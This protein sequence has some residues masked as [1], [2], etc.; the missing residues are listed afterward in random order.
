MQIPK[1][2]TGLGVTTA[3][4][5]LISAGLCSSA[6]LGEELLKDGGF[7]SSTANGTFP[8]SGYWVKEGIGW[9]DAV[10]TTTAGRV[11]HGLWLYTGV[12]SN[13]WWAAPYQQVPATGGT[14]YVGS[15]WIRTPAGQA[16]ADGTRVSVHV[17]F[18]NAKTNVITCYD[19][20]WFEARSL[21]WRQYSVVTDAA[22][23]DTAWARLSCVIY[24]PRGVEGQSIVNFDLCSLSRTS[25]VSAQLSPRAVGF[26][27]SAT[28]RTVSLRNTGTEPFSW[29]IQAQLDGLS[30]NPS[31]G[32]LD[33]ASTVALNLYLNRALLT[34]EGTVS[35]SFR[36]EGAG[37]NQI[38]DVFVEST[39]D[40]VPRQPS[41]VRCYGRQLRVQDRLPDG[42]LGPPYHYAIRGVAWSPA[43]I[44]TYNDGVV[45]RE[46]FQTWYVADTQL[47]RAMNAN[48]VYTFM[49]FGTDAAGLN[50]LDYLYRNGLKA[51]VTVDNNGTADTNKIK[52][53]IPAYRDHP[54]V[55]A[56]AIG[57]EW[58]INLYHRV[59]P[60]TE[61]PDAQ[62]Q[63]FAEFTDQLAQLVKSLDT[64]HP[65]VSI[66]GDIDPGDGPVAMTNI[67]N[68]FAPTV[69]IWGLNAY[70]GPSFEVS[71]LGNLFEDWSRITSEVPK[72]FFL[73]EFGTDVF[74]TRNTVIQ[75]TGPDQVDVVSADG[76]IDERLQANWVRGLWR[77][78]ANHLSAQAIDDPCVGGCI[79]EWNDEWWKARARAGA[80]PGRQETL[81]FWTGWNIDALADSFANE[82]FFAITTIDRVPRQLY[83]YLQED[84]AAVTLSDDIDEDGLPDPW[85]YAV[86]DASETDGLGHISAV[87]PGDDFDGDGASNAL[88]YEADTDPLEP[89]SFL[90]I[91]GLVSTDG[92]LKVEWQGG[93]QAR[94]I[95]EAAEALGQVW[96][97]VWTN[98]P[99]TPVTGLYQEADPGAGGTRYFR[100]RVQR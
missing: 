49:D 74:A 33:A 86:V 55:L 51:I 71:A 82:E 22:P 15:A 5:T 2:R 4:L 6:A 78:I 1:W 10:C 29:T 35:G 100:L 9:A 98:E 24:K 61:I 40:P 94:Q 64:N 75:I 37:T 87:L 42:T 34:G 62:L 79:F 25:V 66:F 54:A 72:P 18:L 96:T 19:S 93:T 63:Q 90:R 91:T 16:W 28:T 80:V 95:L 44:G 57:N 45:R 27:L 31:G 48:T 46:A 47:L 68:Q 14:G 89:S 76:S 77:E 60:G 17:S 65:V 59:E 30:V 70:R 85:E 50:V 20:P 88:E 83:R 36:F 92:V 43:S 13:D 3:V 38:V 41:L 81:G 26:P 11:G 21:A 32:V 39:A 23:S 56:W 53:V 67:I 73:S 58:N 7:E 12:S 97:P 69:D 99:P 8:D 52:S 84:F